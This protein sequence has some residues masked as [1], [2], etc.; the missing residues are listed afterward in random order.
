[1][2]A[3][4]STAKRDTSTAN[5]P[6]GTDSVSGNLSVQENT[7]PGNGASITS[8]PAQE[9]QKDADGQAEDSKQDNFILIAVQ[10]SETAPADKSSASSQPV[11]HTDTDAFAE[12]SPG[13]TSP[14]HSY[15]DADNK[16]NLTESR[17]YNMNTTNQ[18]Q[19]NNASETIAPP[20]AQAKSSLLSPD[21]SLE[22]PSVS[23]NN[24]TAT[25]WL[26]KDSD[27]SD[28]ILTYLIDAAFGRNVDSDAL[29]EAVE[30]GKITISTEETPAPAPMSLSSAIQNAEQSATAEPME[31]AVPVITP[32]VSE[33]APSVQAVAIIGNNGVEAVALAPNAQTDGETLSRIF[34]LLADARNNQESYNTIF[35]SG[36]SVSQG[37]VEEENGDLSFTPSGKNAATVTVSALDAS[38]H[39]I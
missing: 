24:D 16:S 5:P 10:P 26:S 11:T 3:S 2:A 20:S 28:E 17:N 4:S 9:S 33:N 27:L 8:S 13:S 7:Q 30:S 36:A 22:M 14:D 21:A 1:M 35:G 37:L 15:T 23:S 32:A 29:T 34:S 38:N 6:V 25:L 19:V 18:N 31:T 12:N 39:I